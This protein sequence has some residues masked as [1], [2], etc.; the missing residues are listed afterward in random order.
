MIDPRYNKDVAIM[1]VIAN[2]LFKENL[3]NKEYVDRFV[4]PKGFALWKDYVLGVSDD[5]DKTPKWAEKICAVPAET[6]RKFARLYA[7]SKPASL[8]FGWCAARQYQGENPA[9]A[10]MYL[11]ALTRNIGVVGVNSTY[12]Q[13]CDMSVPGVTIYQ[14]LT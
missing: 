1:L 11:Q 9:R 6:I 14:T 3:Y 4:E 2:V 12:R 7:R 5:V 10:A 13:G 8:I